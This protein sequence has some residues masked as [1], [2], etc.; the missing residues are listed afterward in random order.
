[1]VERI[2]PFFQRGEKS[3]GRVSLPKSWPDNLPLGRLSSR[4]EGCFDVSGREDWSL[5]HRTNRLVNRA[6]SV[7]RQVGGRGRRL[8]GLDAARLIKFRKRLNKALKLRA[9]K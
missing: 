5:D 6:S 3:N 1:M 9:R 8:H 4:A 7:G 2:L